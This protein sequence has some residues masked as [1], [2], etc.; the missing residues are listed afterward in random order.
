LSL[1]ESHLEEHDLL[2]A[3]LGSI[4]RQKT[5]EQI[6]SFIRAVSDT[7]A[8]NEELMRLGYRTETV[9]DFAR[10]HG[11]QFLPEELDAYF[12]RCIQANIPEWSLGKREQHLALHRAGEIAEPLVMDRPHSSVLDA[13][14]NVPGFALD[15]AAILGGTVTVAR[16]FS[17][18]H[19]LTA[20]LREHL[21]CAFESHDLLTVYKSLSLQDISKRVEVAYKALLQDTSIPAL[22]TDLTHELGMNPDDIIFE[23]PGFRLMFPHKLGGA[24]FYRDGQTGSVGPHRDTWY[25]SPQHQLNF[26]GPLYPLSDCAALHVYPDYFF[27]SIENNT[28]GYDVWRNCVGLQLNPLG[29]QDICV[30]DPLTPDLDVGDAMIF[31]AH[32]LHAGAANAGDQMR[33]SF[34][35]R[36]LNREDEGAAYA[37]PN[38]DYHGI[39]Y[40]YNGWFRLDGSEVH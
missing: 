40:I 18:L 10:A 30:D 14:E 25:G 2:A 23:W 28:H 35:F 1:S 19:S 6:E 37:P 21:E 16:Q 20:R 4:D 22:M 13:V 24:G 32:H 29:L 34:E 5:K 31:A 8:L 38:I 11:F 33:V 15:R 7:P 26:W 17:A 36:I 3:F 27:R 12:E 39:G 9:A